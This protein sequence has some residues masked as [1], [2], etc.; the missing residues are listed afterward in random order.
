MDTI[1]NFLAKVQKL[2][3]VDSGAGGDGGGGG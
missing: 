2:G 3:G 1:I